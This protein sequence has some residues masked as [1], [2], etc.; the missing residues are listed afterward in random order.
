MSSPGT[1]HFEGCPKHP[2]ALREHPDIYP[3]Q[4]EQINDDMLELM[5]EWE[6]DRD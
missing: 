1:E 3:C 4:C 6:P 5:Y 2:D